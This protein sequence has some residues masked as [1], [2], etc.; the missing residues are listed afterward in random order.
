MD[1]FAAVVPMCRVMCALLQTT[2][3]GTTSQQST[4]P[5][6]LLVLQDIAQETIQVMPTIM[7]QGTQSIL[8]HEVDSSTIT[9]TEIRL[10]FPKDLPSGNKE[11]FRKGHPKVAFFSLIHRAG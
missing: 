4:T 10:T 8:V 1:T 5:T 7:E 9:A 11:D 3:T 2:P 6:H